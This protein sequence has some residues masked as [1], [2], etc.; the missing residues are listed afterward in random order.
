[1]KKIANQLDRFKSKTLREQQFYAEKAVQDAPKET[2]KII[3]ALRIPGRCLL[4]KN[5]K[6]EIAWSHT[7]HE[8]SSM[9]Q[10]RNVF[11]GH[12]LARK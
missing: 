5:A 2:S 8:E 9:V 7:M 6:D 10:V 3:R 1:M 11:Q 12:C 4:P